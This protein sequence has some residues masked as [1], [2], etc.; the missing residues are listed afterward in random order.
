MIH[1]SLYF[2]IVSPKDNSY[3]CAS[4]LTRA[5]ESGSTNRSKQST[6]APRGPRR[7][8]FQDTSGARVT[9]L[10]SSDRILYVVRLN[11]NTW[12]FLEGGRLVQQA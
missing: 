12:F 3:R 9:K 10:E 6:T 2:A 11:V 1:N 5:I 4:L 8:H 7:A